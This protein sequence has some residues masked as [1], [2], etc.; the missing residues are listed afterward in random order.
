MDKEQAEEAD[1]EDSAKEF[2]K[3]PKNIVSGAKSV[4]KKFQ[5]SR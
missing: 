5:I 2:D 4:P 3:G 1:W